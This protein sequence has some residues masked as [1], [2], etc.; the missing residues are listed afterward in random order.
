MLLSCQYLDE[1]PLQLFVFSGPDYSRETIRRTNPE[2][3]ALAEVTP[4]AHAAIHGF[5]TVAA[6]LAALDRHTGSLFREALTMVR[7]AREAYA[8]IGGKYPHSESIVPGG[9]A[10]ALSEQK[11]D[12]FFHKLR[13]FVDYSKRCIAIWNEIFDFLAV[14]NPAYRHLGEGPATMID[15]GQWD[16]EDVYDASYANCDTWGESRWSTPGAIVDGNLVTTRLTEL[17]AGLEEQVDRSF[18][19]RTEGGVAYRTDPLGNPISPN[20]PWN[21]RFAANPAKSGAPTPYSWATTM[22]WRGRT[23]EVGAYARIY[24]SALGKKLPPSRH[25]S[26][27]GQ[28]L[29]FHLPA[30]VLP[31]CSLEWRPPPI[32]NAFERNRAR[33]YAVAFNYLVMTENYERARRLL[34]AGRPL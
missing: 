18:Y 8:V 5:V 17:N 29:V 2:I 19:D 25:L 7:V 22:T 14:A 4:A 23:F 9:V 33:A 21:R 12:D 32:W 15:F 27:T 6:L 28:S 13:P 34:A 24:L 26:S 20:H 16:N 11:L 3:W 10:L 30:D 1:N 31:A